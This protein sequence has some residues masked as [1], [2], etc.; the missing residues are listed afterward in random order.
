VWVASAVRGQRQPFSTAKRQVGVNTNLRGFKS[1]SVPGR[2][3]STPRSVDGTWPRS[4]EGL[5]AEHWKGTVRL[6][7]MLLEN[8]AMSEDIAQ[9]AFVR[10]GLK[11]N[12]GAVASPEAY[13]RR[14]VVNLCRSS[15][16]RRLIAAR[17]LPRPPGPA[18]AADAALLESQTREEVLAALR[19]L[20]R[21][22]REAMVLRYYG[23]LSLSEIATAMQVSI[24]TVKSTLSKGTQRFAQMLEESK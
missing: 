15:F 7:A 5:Y 12:R 23:E 18:P 21:R 1:R 2:G 10:L 6:A 20:P 17:H 22:Q 9:E 24:G 19:R 14:I 16:R 11:G 13:L 3:E 8:P 4:L